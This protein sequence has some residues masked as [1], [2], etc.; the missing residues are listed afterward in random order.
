[1]KPLEPS[2]RA[3]AEKLLRVRALERVRVR[4]AR[5]AVVVMVV[6]VMVVRLGPAD[7]QRVLQLSAR[8]LRVSAGRLGRLQ[9]VAVCEQRG[10]RLAQLEPH[11]GE[12]EQHAKVGCSR[13]GGGALNELACDEGAPLVVCAE[14]R[15]EDCVCARRELRLC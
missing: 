6:V 1:M 11:V 10:A 5:A 12:G 13:E 14:A 15:L 4:M 9:R 2:R 8:H 7:E 3:V